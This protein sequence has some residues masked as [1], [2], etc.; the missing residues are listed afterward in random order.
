M[1]KKKKKI[2][3]WSK[4]TLLNRGW[5]EKSINEILKTHTINVLILCSYGKHK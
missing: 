4:T 1:E 2:T 3:Y 5:T